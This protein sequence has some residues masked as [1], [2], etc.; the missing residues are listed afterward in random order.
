MAE[1]ENAEGPESGE[2]PK[3]SVVMPTYNAE[4]YL[5]QAI[6]SVL[7]QTYRDFEFL[8]VNDG[9][10]DG[11]LDIA[12]A[13]AQ[14]DPRIRI[15][16]QE[17]QGGA[18]ARNNGMEVARGEWIA[19]MDADDLMLPNRLERQLAF[20]RENPDVAVASAFVYHIDAQNRVIGQN[21]SDLT[22]REMLQR[23]LTLNAPF[24]F[25][26]PAVILNKKTVQ[27]VGGY[28][29]QFEPAEDIDLWNR[30][31][32]NGHTVLVQPEFLLKYRIHVN[33]VCALKMREQ[34][35]TS[36]WMEESLRRRRR[37][38]PEPTWEQYQ[39]I[40]RQM[41]WRAR[42][43]E[44]RSNW[45]KVLYKT[46]V[47]SFVEGRYHVMIPNLVAAYV[48]TPR[49]VRVKVW[50][51]FLKPRMQWLVSKANRPDQQMIRP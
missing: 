29:P 30:V 39:D 32:E 41:G 3:V 35:E 25:S 43:R 28:R 10:S 34:V 51:K 46:A 42:F 24:G 36:R 7:A 18:A 15:I 4:R 9:S 31:A 11:T 44:N 8:I 49:A 5:A 16:S 17:N 1:I 27:A 40:R 19:M 13:Y 21:E 20:L 47:N 37:G 26:H 23:K 22:N 14:K 48:M 38:E 45:G 50:S 33:S 6:D 12:E 2:T